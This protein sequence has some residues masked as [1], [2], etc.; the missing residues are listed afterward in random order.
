MMV[1][2]TTTY[3]GTGTDVEQTSRALWPFLIGFAIAIVVGLIVLV[4]P[5]V[6]KAR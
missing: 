6:L 2:S 1:T 3:P 4:R 5:S